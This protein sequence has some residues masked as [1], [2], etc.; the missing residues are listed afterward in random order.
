MSNFYRSNQNNS[1]S[2]DSDYSPEYQTFLPNNLSSNSMRSA[3][4]SMTPSY[5][6]PNQRFSS[7]N[8]SP[9]SSNRNLPRLNGLSSLNTRTP[10]SRLGNSSPAFNPLPNLSKPSSSRRLSPPLPFLEEEEEFPNGTNSNPATLKFDATLKKDANEALLEIGA[11]TNANN[12]DIMKYYYKWDGKKYVMD[13][14][15]ILKHRDQF[16][17]P[18]K[19]IRSPVFN[20]QQS[21]PILPPLPSFNSRQNLPQLPQLPSFNSRQN[22]PQLPS[23]N[24]QQILPSLELPKNMS[25][26]LVKSPRMN[27]RSPSFDHQTY[28]PRMSPRSPTFDHQTYS[29][30]SVRS[31]P[32][33]PLSS[34]NNTHQLPPLPALDYYY[35]N[36]QLPP[37]PTYFHQ[38]LPELPVYP[39]N[40][41]VVQQPQ[42]QREFPSRN[43]NDYSNRNS[44]QS[45]SFSE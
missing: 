2:D 37:L 29:P 26:R 25:P 32:K 10:T 5:S 38:P 30:R 39:Y 41:H 15:D 1:P 23:F 45:K 21:L 13:M 4:I 3:R 43:S 14:A 7:P 40:D 18:T 12:R 34:F 33:Q 42:P 24:N 11:L 44:S 8:L 36:H 16:E 20:H 27:P 35:N 9:I 22:L 19:S 6:S 28:S 31:P 17:Y